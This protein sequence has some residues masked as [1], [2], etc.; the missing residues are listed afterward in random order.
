[1][2]GSRERLYLFIKANPAGAC[3]PKNMLQFLVIRR[4]VEC[5]SNLRRLVIVKLSDVKRTISH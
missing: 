5:M 1:M 4:N 3:E 2:N